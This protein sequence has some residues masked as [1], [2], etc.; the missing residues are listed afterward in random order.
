[1]VGK[2]GPMEVPVVLIERAVA[3]YGGSNPLGFT[4]HQL[5]AV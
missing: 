5:L 3:G 1:M 2:I 4:G